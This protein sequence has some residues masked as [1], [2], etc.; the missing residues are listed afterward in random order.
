MKKLAL[1]I[2]TASLLAACNS[3]PKSHPQETPAVSANSKAELFSAANRKKNFGQV[4]FSSKINV[5]TDRN[6]PRL[7]GTI[8]IEEGQ[9]IWV[10][11]SAA[12]I[13]VARALITNQGV[14]AYESINKEFVDED[15]SYLNKLLSTNFINYQSFQDLLLGRTF[16]DVNARE[17]SVAETSQGY[18][19]SSIKPNKIS[20]DGK[21]FEYTAKLVY[22]K[23][24]E[25]NSVEI[26]EKNYGESVSIQY[27][28]RMETSAGSLPKNVKIIT[29]GKKPVEISLE[30]TKFDFAKMNAPFSVPQN[31][32][33]KEI[34]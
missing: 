5:E 30:N 4:K 33:K 34:K 11:V 18:T 19:F 24:F 31:Y 22:S 3:V 10:N 8:Y 2:A 13:N 26:N 15:F 9:K 16:I 28:N 1:I 29:K 21:T 32:K 14:K 27:G 20:A 12:F 17:F 25:L 6:V 7:N 23:N